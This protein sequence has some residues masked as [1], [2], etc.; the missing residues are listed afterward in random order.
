MV[1]DVRVTGLEFYLMI[2]GAG[3]VCLRRAFGSMNV[4]SPVV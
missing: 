1:I 2:A 3:S 4:R